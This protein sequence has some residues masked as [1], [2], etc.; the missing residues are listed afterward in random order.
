MLPIYGGI[1]ARDASDPLISNSLLNPVNYALHRD[2][3]LVVAGTKIL[4]TRSKLMP[5]T[6]Y[7]SK[8][9]SDPY[10]AVRE[11]I[12]SQRESSVVYP[13]GYKCPVAN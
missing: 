3:K 12:F 2:F 10:I 4:H 9:S 8:N 1:S 6:D 11:A 13:A 7:V 5:F